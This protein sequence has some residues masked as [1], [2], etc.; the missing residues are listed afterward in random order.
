MSE[1]IVGYDGT[2]CSKAALDQAVGLAKELGD[3]LVI[4]F[5]Y[6]PPGYAGGE[7]KAHQDAIRERGA[8]ITAEA[9]RSATEGGVENEVELVPKRP[10]EALSDLATQRRA[11]MIVIG[12]YGESPLKGAVLGSTPHKLLHL[13]EAPVLV[14]RA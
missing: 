2:E 13:S 5:G 7:M 10:A 3:K 12:S 11:R 9:A 6:A 14:V 1:I 8:E 4:A